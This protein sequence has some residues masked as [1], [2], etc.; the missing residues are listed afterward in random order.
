M[1]LEIIIPYFLDTGSK[2]IK[3]ISFQGYSKVKFDKGVGRGWI[4]KIT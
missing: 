3:I 4:A 2:S 1:S